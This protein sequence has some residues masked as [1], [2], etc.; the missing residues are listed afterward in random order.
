MGVAVGQDEAR[1]VEGHGGAL[2]AATASPAANK[3][4]HGGGEFATGRWWRN[5]EGEGGVS[6]L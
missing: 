4:W 6:S 1:A 3:E 2:R 5:W